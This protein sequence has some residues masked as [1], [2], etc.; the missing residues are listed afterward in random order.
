MVTFLRWASWTAVTSL[1][2]AESNVGELDVLFPRSYI[3]Q[4]VLAFQNHIVSFVV[5]ANHFALDFLIQTRGI[6]AQR[7]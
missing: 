5:N 2:N 6:N 3:Q 1:A 4:R 7:M